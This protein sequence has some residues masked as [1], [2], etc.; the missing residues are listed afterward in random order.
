MMTWKY[1]IV[2]D[3]A[4]S[5]ERLARM[6]SVLFPELVLLKI[7]DSVDG[8]VQW[9]EENE[10]PDLAFF[11]I[12]LS[13]GLSFQVFEKAAFAFPV[14]FTTAFDE[15]AIRAFKVNSIDYLL[16]PLDPKDLST[17]VAKFKSNAS[18]DIQKSQEA[19][20][21]AFAQMT[22]NY[23]SRFVIRIGEHLKMIAASETALFLS[24]EKST[25]LRTFDNRDYGIGYTLEQ[26]ETLVDPSVFYRVS[27][28]YI[29]HIKAIQDIIHYSN[30]RLKL[31]LTIRCDEEVLVSRERLDGFR[32]WIEG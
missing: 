3:E 4:L 27:R 8:T 20:A 13:D 6:I 17:A 29:V 15:Y 24:S 19:I 25:F 10:H 12:Q 9:L 7:L 11:D 30:S 22:Q 31:K 5:A 16:K 18:T 2:E 1:I 32:K 21:L 23:K 28:K 14:I 26:L